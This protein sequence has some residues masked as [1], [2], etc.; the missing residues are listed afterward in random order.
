MEKPDT[1]FKLVYHIETTSTRELI[2]DKDPFVPMAKKEDVPLFAN[3]NPIMVANQASFDAMNEIMESQNIDKIKDYKQLRPTIMLNGKYV[4]NLES[5]F[6]FNS[7]NKVL[8]ILKSHKSIRIPLL[9]FFE[10]VNMNI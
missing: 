8:M 6:N 5:K 1:I 4:K 2:N 7:H 9:K 3:K 10:E